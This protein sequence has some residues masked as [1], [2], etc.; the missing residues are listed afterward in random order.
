MRT[1]GKND[2]LFLLNFQPAARKVNLGRET[3][4]DI[5]ADKGVRGMVTL[6][7][8]GSLIVRRPHAD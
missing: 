6:P 3:F 1:D 7:A 5:V 4:T 2:F 8:Y